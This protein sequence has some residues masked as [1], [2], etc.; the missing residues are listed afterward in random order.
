MKGGAEPEAGELG[1]VAECVGDHSMASGPR[2]MSRTGSR[3]SP[4]WDMV[5]C[6]GQA[7]GG[8][9]VCSEL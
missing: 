8:T 6:P 1:F 5:R 7:T 9:G 3:M 2:R 4:G